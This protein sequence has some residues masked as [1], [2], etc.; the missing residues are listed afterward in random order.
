MSI[1]DGTL[2][3]L[4]TALGCG[5]LIGI[6]RERRKGSGPARALAGVRTFT[7]AALT[8]AVAQS[9]GQPLL[10][11]AGGVLILA[12][13]AIGYFYD[14]RTR[15][16]A[17][18]PG[19]TTELALFVTFLLGVTA[20]EHASLAAA[21]AVV[22]AI[23]LAARSELHR[24]STEVLNADELRDALLLFGAALVVLP[25]LPG[26]P[27]EWLAG[28]DPHRLWGLVVLLMALQAAG[29]VAL[30]IAGARLGLALSGLVSGFVSSTAT[31]AA[32]G[33]RARAEPRLLSACVAGALFSNVAT[34]IELALVAVTISPAALP[35]IAPALAAAALAAAAVALVSLRAAVR[36]SHA[37]RPSGRA[38][39][40]STA[41]AFATLLT[42]VTAA[43]SFTTARYGGA[44]A[45]VT[46][47][48]AG[49][50]DVHAAAASVFSLAA[51]DKIPPA[52]LLLPVLIAFTTNT[53]SKLVAAWAAGG[54]RYALRV[55][56]GLLVVTAAV[57]APWLASAG[58]R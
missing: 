54:P 1:G 4:A 38:F 56:G 15:G 42:A 20:I 52:T 55:A 23:L 9:L 32:M 21:A 6:E 49:F 57:W 51:S 58:E 16:R 5:L 19:V 30:R 28:V 33:A 41:L 44:A 37:R 17:S 8:G 50:V 14:R 35:V 26:R 22:V 53:V 13:A 46:A 27:L 7:L 24:F 18:D 39:S 36:G 10:V 25:L 2:L 48:L 45:G 34:P 11:G 29:Y 31:V 40:L 12:L 47:A 43:A 3:G